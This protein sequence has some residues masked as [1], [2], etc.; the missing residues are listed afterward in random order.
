MLRNES[1]KATYSYH[2]V[3]H[4]SDLGR[5]LLEIERITALGGAL[6]IVVPHFSSPYF[7]SDP[8]HKTNFGLYTLSYFTKTSPFKRKVPNYGFSIG[9]AI[10]KVDLIFKSDASFPVRYVM[11]R[12]LGA[13]F[14]SCNYMREFYEENFCYLFPCYELRYVLRRI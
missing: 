13:I 9:F 3:E 11:K 7:Y 5:F 2:F 4:L 10:A 6:E 8:T 12:S 1:V 14:N